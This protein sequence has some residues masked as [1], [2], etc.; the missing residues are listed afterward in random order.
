MTKSNLQRMK[1]EWLKILLLFLVTSFVISC[2][3]KTDNGD[4]IHLK[5]DNTLLANVDYIEI[6]DLN[7][8]PDI[9]GIAS[10][11]DIIND[12]SLLISTTT[13][14]Q[15]FVFN[16]N[17]NQALKVGK[18]GKGPNEYLSPSIVK[19]SQ[20]EIYVWCSKQL[21]L[22][23]FDI[24]GEAIKQYDFDK[25][26]KD[27]VIFKN[28]V[29]FYTVGGLNES[30]ITIFDLSQGQFINKAF[31]S[32]TKEHEILNMRE[33]SGGIVI[34]DSLLFFTPTNELEVSIV[35]LSKFILIKKIKIEDSEFKTQKVSGDINSFL[36]DQA[37]SIQYIYGASRVLGIFPTKLGII[38]RAEVGQIKMEG[39]NFK[40][41]SKR[42]NKTYVFD[43]D[44]K[45]EGVHKERTMDY[46]NQIYFSDKSTIYSIKLNKSQETYIWE[47]VK[48]NL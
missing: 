23:V 12:S 32:L 24:N 15:V 30:L 41:V 37:E 47:E 45:L 44:L 26:V 48:I 31:G 42:M 46:V 8:D 13:P 5:V 2:T 1:N 33:H 3:K 39:L 43:A 19:Y 38:L 16:R 28:Y 36:R 6:A 18:I 14:P 20:D 22:I 35:D 27:F 9:I 21:R 4:V 34:K 29:C 25:A 40:D 11:A 17:G 7:N 10:Y